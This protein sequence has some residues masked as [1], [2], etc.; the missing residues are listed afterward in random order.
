MKW[1]NATSTEG[2]PEDDI[3]IHAKLMAQL[4]LCESTNKKAK[5]VQKINTEEAHNYDSLVCKIEEKIESA[6][7]DI[8]EVER[9]VEEAKKVRRNR[10]EYD[11]LASEIS[12]IPDRKLTTSKLEDIRMD[13]VKL[14]ESSKKSLGIRCFGQ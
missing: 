12:L 1:C 6:S 2:D 8:E 14:K 11:A 10:L 3:K 5:I 9:E 7:K 13:L 4:L